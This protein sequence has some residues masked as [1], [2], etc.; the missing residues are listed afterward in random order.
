MRSEKTSLWGKVTSKKKFRRKVMNSEFGSLKIR[1]KGTIFDKC[2]LKGIYVT[3][4]S[5]NTMFT[6]HFVFT[7]TNRLKTNIPVKSL[8]EKREQNIQ[9]WKY[10]QKEQSFYF[11][12][13]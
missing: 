11:F 5:K 1:K 10:Y 13:K 2:I 6:I 12:G 3:E 4:I 8:L 7:T 9:T